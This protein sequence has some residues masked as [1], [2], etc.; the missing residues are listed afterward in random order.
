MTRKE[1]HLSGLAVSGGIAFG[2]AYKYCP[3]DVKMEEVE[4]GLGEP[5]E[6]TQI[7]KNALNA[8]DQELSELY[9]RA[10]L[11]GT[12]SAKIFEA[13]REILQDEEM[14]EEILH[15]ITEQKIGPAAAVDQ[16]FSRFADL[17][18]RVTDP[19][20]A[21]R[22]AD[23]RDVGQR[24]LRFLLKIER[25]DLACLPPG[26][27]L[28]AHDLLPSDTAQLDPEHVKGIVT[29]CGSYTSHTAILSR[30]L[31]IPAILGVADVLEQVYSGE[32][33][34]VDG[35]AG[36]VY[37]SPSEDTVKTLQQRVQT[38]Q[39]EQQ[40][41]HSFLTKPAVTR[42][43]VPIDIG[44]NIG[45]EDTD[46]SSC[47]FCGLFRTEFLFLDKAAFPSEEEQFRCY[48]DIVRRADGKDVVLRTLD[49]G[50]DKS[51]PYLSLPQEENPFLGKRALRLCFD[52]TNIFR[53]QLRAVLRASAYGSLKI[54]YPMVG[55]LE[56]FRRAKA[57]ALSVMQELSK[58]GIDFNPNIEQG[59]MIEIPAIAE[60]ADLAAQEVDFAS[61]GTNDLCQYLCAADRLNPS[62]SQYYQSFSPAVLRCLEKIAVA[63]QNTG[64]PLSVCGEM[65]GDI[66][67]AKLL[68]GLGYRKLSMSE[69]HIGAIKDLVCRTSLADAQM[70]AREALGCRT[71]EEVL[72]LICDV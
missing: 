65:G 15:V 47:D 8:V 70:L 30:S 36:M 68:I 49:I 33:A 42:D 40:R 10:S 16:V 26:T 22:V 37:L 12:E 62:V 23:I 29:E 5:A 46:F 21:A 57:E 43:G 25:T 31:G 51:L 54:M 3:D 38:F 58:E 67:A 27:I 1:R 63:F 69:P 64:K 19:L 56:D 72:H 20:I 18:G 11:S 32:Q 41:I 34:A 7:Y 48:R 55:S 59:I 6:D 2:T 24:L 14:K 13:Q 66:R 52:H 35:S 50:G 60:I 71:E 53:T 17:L 61:V 28:I 9:R 39:E 4:M 44:I 45:G